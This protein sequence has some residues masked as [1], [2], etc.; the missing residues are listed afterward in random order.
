MS[1]YPFAK[2]A[3]TGILAFLTAVSVLVETQ[4]DSPFI[5]AP[6][7]SVPYLL[8]NSG[9]DTENPLVKPDMD[10]SGPRTC[11]V[12]CPADAPRVLSRSKDL[13]LLSA[14]LPWPVENRPPPEETFC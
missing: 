1:N 4:P 7:H 8:Q 2:I 6:T 13:P 3:L 5:A 10:Y 14:S 9:D 11:S 12:P